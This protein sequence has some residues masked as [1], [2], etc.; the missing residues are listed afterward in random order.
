V[1]FR[2]TGARMARIRINE[3]RITGG[4]IVLQGLAFRKFEKYRVT[5]RGLK[6][7]LIQSVS[8]KVL[9]NYVFDAWNSSGQ[10]LKLN[11]RNTKHAASPY[12]SLPNVNITQSCSLIPTNRKKKNNM[13][14]PFS[15][16]N[17]NQN[18]T[19]TSN[20]D[21]KFVSVTEDKETKYC[22]KICGVKFYTERDTKAMTRYVSTELRSLLSPVSQQALKFLGLSCVFTHM[23]FWYGKVSNTDPHANSCQKVFMWKPYYCCFLNNL[24]KSQMLFF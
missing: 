20:R 16:F 13:L 4:T 11:Q 17:C 5:S 23:T 1:V 18:N 10:Y 3:V 24:G 19:S 2:I 15:N 7:N 22:R 8:D 12:S 14:H 9:R 21:R 6:A